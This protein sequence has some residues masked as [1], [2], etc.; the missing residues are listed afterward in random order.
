MRPWEIRLSHL[1]VTLFAIVALNM[2]VVEAAQKTKKPPT[3]LQGSAIMEEVDDEDAISID[4]DNENEDA[5]DAE[6]ATTPSPAPKVKEDPEVKGNK[7]KNN[8]NKEKKEKKNKKKDKKREK[9]MEGFGKA[10]DF[11]KMWFNLSS[12]KIKTSLDKLTKFCKIAC[13]AD[14]CADEEIANNCHLICPE[15]TTKKCP[16]PLKKSRA[17]NSDEEEAIEEIEETEDTISTDDVASPASSPL[18]ISPDV[19]DSIN[20]GER[21]LMEDEGEGG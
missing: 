11:H 9:L 5:G 6:A 16:D 20:Q 14:Q 8:S 10:E 18:S 12:A 15:A 17:K 1:W 3:Q 13:T 2:G 19:T 7:L 4:E 21:I